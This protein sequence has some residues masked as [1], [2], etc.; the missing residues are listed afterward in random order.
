MRSRG[1]SVPD[2]EAVER[3][4]CGRWRRRPPRCRPGTA[5]PRRP[6]WPPRQAARLALVWVSLSLP[7]PLAGVLLVLFGEERKRGGENTRKIRSLLGWIFVCEELGLPWWQL[8]FLAHGNRDKE[9]AVA[10]GVTGQ[11]LKQSSSTV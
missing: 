4:R 11:G 2:G 3:G 8:D 10:D 1:R 9:R 5:P 7:L 6:A